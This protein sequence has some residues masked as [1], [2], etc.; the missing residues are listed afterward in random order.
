[1]VSS[2]NT[3]SFG[4]DKSHEHYVAQLNN[5]KDLNFQEIIALYTDYIESHPNDIIAQIELCKFIGSS[6]IDEYEEY[7]LKYDETEECIEKLALAN[8]SN[9]KVIIYKAEN[10]YGA[11]QLEVLNNAKELIDKEKTRWTD[12]EIATINKMLGDSHEENNWLSLSHYKKAQRLNDSLDLSLPIARIYKNQGKNDEA[13]EVLLHNL[14]KDTTKWILNQKANL[15]IELNSPEKALE[16]YEIITLKDSTFI[17]NTE[18][19]D[20]MTELGNHK[21]AREFLV[22]DTVQEWGKIGKLQTLFSHDLAHSSPETALTTYR[23]LQEESSYDDFFGIKRFRVFIRDPLLLWNFSELLHLGMLWVLLIVMFLIPYIWVLPV[24]GIGELLRTNGIKV[25]PKLNFTWSIR[26]FW[27]VSFFYLLV[28]VVVV[29]VFE[30]KENMNYYFD[31]DNSYVVEEVNVKLLANEAILFIVLMAVAT[32]FVLKGKKIRDVFRTNLSIGQM[33]GLGVLFV[34]FNRFFLR[35][36]GS[37]VDLENP[38]VSSNT[39]LSAQEEI[40]ALMSNYGFLPTIFLVALVVP[41]YEEIIFRGVILSAAEKHIGFTGANVV[42]AILFALIHDNLKLFPFFFVFALVT[43]YFVKRSGGL[44][45][46]IFFHSIHN[47]SVLVAIYYLTR[48]TVF[49][50]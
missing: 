44:L 48:L 43:G 16:L 40:T 29:F 39:F 23:A 32:L 28:S 50:G 20:A 2:Q 15:L 11:E 10:L 12:N 25:T 36:L 3:P 49:A 27:I 38:I 4:S 35:I 6:Y 5:A 30:Y 1:M 8:P 17:D 26:H 33:I 9:P 46:G 14:K 19:A 22:R 34:I 21:A 45:T 18:M 37:F 24:Y 31:L 47:F 7:N 41:V 42:Q 13:R